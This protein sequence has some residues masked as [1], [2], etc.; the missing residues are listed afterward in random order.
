MTLVSALADNW[1]I[2]GAWVSAQGGSASRSG[3]FR[4]QLSLVLAGW[5]MADVAEDDA[6]DV[7]GNGEDVE[8]DLAEHAEDDGE[9]AED[10]GDHVEADGDD[11][12]D[13]GDVDG[14][15]VGDAMFRRT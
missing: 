5:T 15:V 7:E 6:D 12:E 10:D 9:D 14:D 3:W 11:V 1:E 8:D 13:V 4:L 2:T